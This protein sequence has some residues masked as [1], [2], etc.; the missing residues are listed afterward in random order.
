MVDLASVDMFEDLHRTL[1]QREID[2]R[3]AGVNEQVL[4][5]FETSSL[6]GTHGDIHE[7]ETVA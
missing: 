6:D 2:L 1:K 7:E 4:E 5:I 3:L